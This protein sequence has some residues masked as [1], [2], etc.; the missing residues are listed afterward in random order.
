VLVAGQVLVENT[1]HRFLSLWGLG[2]TALVAAGA[3]VGYGLYWKRRAWPVIDLTL[4]RIGSFRRGVLAGGVCRVGLNALPFVLQMQLQIGFGYSALHAGSIVFALAI[5][6]LLGK[7]L[8]KT[9]VARYGYHRMVVGTTLANA[10]L[11]AGL[12]TLS[13]QWPQIALIVYL[14]GLGFFRSMQF[15]ALNSM[16]YSDV[17]KAQEGASVTVGSAAQQLFMGLGISLSAVAI[18]RF[19]GGQASFDASDLAPVFLCSAVTVLVGGAFFLRGSTAAP[20]K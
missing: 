9:W 15:M 16:I 2:F 11:A 19:S 17:P 18:A 8:L 7:P 10:A 3:A 20:G 1:T 6:T 13:P 4:F 14:T 12:Y 5:G